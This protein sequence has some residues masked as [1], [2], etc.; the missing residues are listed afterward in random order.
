MAI[1][2]SERLK[3]KFG[4]E[5]LHD[6]ITLIENVVVD[7]GI[8]KD[9]LLRIDKINGRIDGI[10]ER[11]ER[12]ERSLNERIEN[13]EARLNE[14]MENLEARLNERMENLEARLNERIEGMEARFDERLDRLYILMNSQIKWMVGTITVF[15]VLISSLITIFKFIG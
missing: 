2:V 9:E 11:M 4:D 1:V 14:R 8:S 12:M 15:G 3:E 7:R 13:L 6:F 5:V 10:H